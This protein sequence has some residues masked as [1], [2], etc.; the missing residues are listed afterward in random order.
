MKNVVVKGASVIKIQ[1]T[2]RHLLE[3]QHKV[4]QLAGQDKPGGELRGKS[5]ASI[6]IGM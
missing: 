3:G 6:S 2:R 1:I 4:Q 5:L